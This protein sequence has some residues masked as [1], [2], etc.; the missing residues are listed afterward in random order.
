LSV[1]TVSPSLGV[2]ADA[3]GLVDPTTRPP[4]TLSYLKVF[5]WNGETGNPPRLQLADSGETAD[6]TVA[7]VVRP[8]NVCKHLTGLRRAIASLRW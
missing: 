3:A 2:A 4:L 1:P 7:N 5:T 6:R 8:R